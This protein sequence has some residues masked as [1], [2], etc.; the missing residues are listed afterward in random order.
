M[1]TKRVSSYLTKKELKGLEVIQNSIPKMYGI[2]NDSATFKFLI[3]NYIQSVFWN[4]ENP[5]TLAELKKAN[6]KKL[7][8]EPLQNIKHLIAI[9]N[10]NDIL[11]AFD[12]FNDYTHLE[13]EV[14]EKKQELSQLQDE[15][16][17]LQAL[18]DNLKKSTSPK[19]TGKSVVKVVKKSIVV[20]KKHEITRI[21]LVNN[22]N[23]DEIVQS[24]DV[25]E[26]LKADTKAFN[27]LMNKISLEYNLTP[28]MSKKEYFEQ[29]KDTDL[30]ELTVKTLEIPKFDEFEQENNAFMEKAQAIL[31]KR[32]EN[33]EQEEQNTSRIEEK[34]AKQREM[35]EQIENNR[36]S[37]SVQ[38]KE[39]KNIGNEV[40]FAL[41]FYEFDEENQVFSDTPNF[42]GSLKIDLS[43]INLAVNDL[44]EIIENQFKIIVFSEN[45]DLKEQILKAID[46]ENYV[47]QI[48]YGY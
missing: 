20:A 6:F 8:N 24:F 22:K 48:E 3:H 36:L 18:R 46:T 11:K 40:D 29:V 37:S 14:D 43:D 21:V 33:K 1:T 13:Q 34:L 42:D 38:Q 47:I 5:E 26:P 7:K 45:S 30:E 23:I 10:G 4:G 16:N 35:L 15:I 9:S 31:D 25:S 44:I 28:M 19:T 39:P 2:N 41:Y 32:K 27:T 17:E 12:K